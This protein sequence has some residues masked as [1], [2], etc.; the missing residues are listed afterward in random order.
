[1]K[2]G[3][4]LRACP[5]VLLLLPEAQLHFLPQGPDK[6]NHKNFVPATERYIHRLNTNRHK[7][8]LS[9]LPYPNEEAAVIPAVNFLGR[10]I[11]LR[12]WFGFSGSPSAGN[13]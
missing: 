5:D 7:T 10:V 12:Q 3:R 2:K 8:P 11:R 1:V 13:R 4:P 6:Q 9:L